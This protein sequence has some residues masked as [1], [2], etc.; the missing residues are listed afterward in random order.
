[1]EATGSVEFPLEHMPLERS[2]HDNT[3]PPSVHTPIAVAPVE[4]GAVPQSGWRFVLIRLG[5]F[6]FGYRDYFFPS[7]FVLLVVTTTPELPFNSTRL[8]YW[9]DRVGLAVIILG[10]GCRL[11]AVGSVD[12]I[13]RGGHRKHIAAH[14]LIRTGIFAHTRNPLYL[15]NLLIVTGLVVIANCR[16]WYFLVLP[17]FVGVYW[18]IV[19]AEEEFLRRQFGP[20]YTAYVQTVNRFVP[21]LRGLSQSLRHGAFSWSRALRKERGVVCTWWFAAMVLLVWEQWTWGAVVAWTTGLPFILL[22]LL[23]T[24]LTYRSI[25]WLRRWSQSRS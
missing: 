19:L 6:L 3:P 24:L 18:A 11:L 16:W 14:L 20:A 12:N 10:Q 21:T 9:L 13:R 15:G 7:V 4:P 8:D 25:L 2:V 1:M 5:R 17:G 22:L 23:L